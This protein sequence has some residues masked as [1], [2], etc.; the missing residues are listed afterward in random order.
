MKYFIGDCHIGDGG[1]TDEF[2][3]K[4]PHFV[5]LIEH[6]LAERPRDEV[7]ELILL[8]DI[9]DFLE[10]PLD[11][12]MMPKVHNMALDP[13]VEYYFNIA[14]WVDVT[15]VD[16]SGRMGMHYGDCPYLRL[17]RDADGTIYADLLDASQ[18]D[19]PPID[20]EKYRR[21]YAEYETKYL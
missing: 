11:P 6:M 21:R 7:Q 19:H 14:S 15:L 12:E 9:F 3:A 20:I 2:G 4:T 13:K 16:R 10:I 17:R 18:P 5:S 1:P 8:G